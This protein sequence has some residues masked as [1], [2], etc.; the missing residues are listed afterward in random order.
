[1]GLFFVPLTAVAFGSVP[2]DKLDEAAGLY[3]LMRGIGSSIGIAVV[4]W[5][6]VRQ[7]QV[8]WADLI[9]HITPFNPAVPPYLSAPGLNPQAPALRAARGARDRPSGADARLRRPVLV[10]RHRDLRH[11][12]AA[13]CMMKRPERDRRVHPG[14]RLSGAR[15]SPKDGRCSPCARAA[16]SNY[17]QTL[18]PEVQTTGRYHARPAHRVGL[19]RHDIRLEVEVRRH[20]VAPI[21]LRLCPRCAHA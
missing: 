6:F 4:S 18:A 12:A 17:Q 13:C 10:H 19:C 5:L 9:T 14:A 7:V 3:A 21:R 15:P 16:V 2:T 1:M 11:P 20:T 8:H